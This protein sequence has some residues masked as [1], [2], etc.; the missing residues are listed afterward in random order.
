M[1]CKPNCCTVFSWGFTSRLDLKDVKPHDK[2]GP[3]RVFLTADKQLPKPTLGSS[4]RRD[5][6]IAVRLHPLLPK[7]VAESH[8]LYLLTDLKESMLALEHI[9][10][11]LPG[12]L[13]VVE[14]SLC[15]Y[16]PPA[17]EKR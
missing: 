14:V 17:S 1:L 13:K 2:P 15:L 3:W 16:C 6:N 11:P 12:S 8:F 9:Y 5:P 4:P 10:S 7:S